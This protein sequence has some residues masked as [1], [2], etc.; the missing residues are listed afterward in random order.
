[1]LILYH[2]LFGVEM[3]GV[4]Q[5]NSIKFCANLRKKCTETLEMIRQAFGEES[6]SHTQKA[7]A[8]QDM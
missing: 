8:L 1:M 7:Q 3:Q 2:L 6:L 4:R 5:R